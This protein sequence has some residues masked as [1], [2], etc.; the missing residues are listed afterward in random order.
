MKVKLFNGKLRDHLFLFSMIFLFAAMASAQKKVTGT[1][2]SKGIP[3]AG[4]NVAAKGSKTG[5]STDIDGKFSINVDNDVKTIVVSYLGYATQEIAVSDKPLTIELSEESNKL[6]EVV[7]NVGYGTQKKSVNTGAIS[8]VSA[9][10]IEKVPNGGVG[11]ALQG[12]V[13]GVMVASNSGAPG[14]LS[15]IRVR[16]VTT[17]GGNS[18]LL[19][20]DGVV[21]PD[22]SLNAINQQ[23]IESMEVLKDA[24][25]AAIYGTRAAKGVILITTK[26]G[27][28]GKI[29]VN[30][31]GFTGSSAPTRKVNLL[32][33]TEYATIMNEKSLAGGGSIVYANPASYGEGTDWQSKIFNNSAKR[34]NHELS[35]SGGNENSTYFMSFG[36]QDTEGIVATDI[37][38][39]I[40]KSVR[41]NTTHKINKYL[42]IGQNFMY[43]NIKNVGVG[44]M[45]TEFGGVMGSALMLDPT[46][47]YIVTDPTKVAQLE[48]LSPWIVRD[49]NG[50]PYGISNVVGQEIVNP[51]ALIQTQR[52]NFGWS[53][54]FIGNLNLELNLIEGL[55][56]KTVVGGKKSYWGNQYFNPKFY[57]N[58]SFN[59]V[60]KNALVRNIG[61]GMDWIITN[62]LTYD[63]RYKD[64]N[65]NALL[66]YEVNESGIG[67]YSGITHSNLQT[68]NYAEANFNMAVAAADKIG[69]SYDFL[70]NRLTSTYGRL[71]YDYKEKYLFTGI[72]RV[73]GSTLFGKNNKYG[74]FPSAS[75]GW[76]VSK[77]DFWKE[78]KIVN[79]FKLRTGYGVNGDIGSLGQFFYA[80]TISGGFNYAFGSTGQISNGSTI[81]TIDNPDLH[82]EETAQ[83]NLGFDTRLMQD[84]NLTFEF[85]NKKT[86]GILQR[87]R[88]PGYT[89]VS[90]SPWANV[91]DMTNKGIE[92]ELGY[93]KTIGKLNIAANANFSTLKNEVTNIG[94]G[95][96]FITQDAAGFQSM[97]EVTRTQVGES[98]NS[99]YGFQTAGIFQNQAEIDAYTNSTG[100]LIQPDAVPGDFRWVDNNGDGQITNDDKKFL[101]SPLPKYTFGFSL[102]LD[103]KGFDLYVFT[104]GVA[105]NKIFQGYRRL[106]VS[107]A[108]FTAEA[109]GRWT[110]EGTSNSYPRITS[111]DTN[112]NFGRMSDFYL[113]DGDY[114][115]LKLV[116]LGYSL[117]Q[118]AIKSIGA[119]K[120]RFYVSAENLLTFTKYKG[121]DPE[122]GGTVMGIDK[123]YYPQART[124]FLGA[125]IQF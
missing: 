95:V 80:S 19:V 70:A 8:R 39:S 62:T 83:F 44:S 123:G 116:Q 79:Y 71:N 16:G 103:Y 48:A 21:M 38:N 100:G 98:V 35:F 114:L 28:K 7:I 117:P 105:G 113:K 86:S 104:Q 14:S 82:W 119:S 125:N 64:H 26:K 65:F 58:A 110:G 108:N 112:G 13:S 41:L 36:L 37:S 72:Y 5:V 46:T 42:T 3:L 63:K 20:I 59:N 52:G 10:D 73:D 78:N 67:N 12:R 109:L 43:T 11:T 22:A 25:S 115:R 124:L 90:E 6:E 68:N 18:P 94:N 92:I 40:K 57:L 15:T 75:L 118:D 33:A 4:A 47:P 106:D 56:F 30:Y 93:K 2:S 17:F 55:K 102:N 9:R 88:V 51:S 49:P 24:A 122:I 77:E 1:V 60:Q 23:D 29:S 61:T 107:E 96:D 81:R 54:D 53:D 74:H 87:V 111:A 97:G 76:V 101:G 84:F 91:A 85:F 89:G 27:K 31:N 34:V 45:N 32:N 69:Y 120:V 121:Y 50:N 99:F 66:G